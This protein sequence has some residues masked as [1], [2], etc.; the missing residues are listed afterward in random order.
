MKLKAAIYCRLSKED[1]DKEN[2]EQ[3][4]QSI[5]NQ[6]MMLLDY[7]KNHDFELYD[8]YKDDDYS[9][10]YDD[11]PEFERLIQDAKDGKFDVVIAKSQSR[12]TRNIEHLEKYLHHDFPLW[13]IR[14]ISVVDNVDTQLKGNKKARQINGLINEWYCEDLSESIKASYLIKQKMGQFLGSAPPYGYLKDPDDNHH[15]IPDPYASEVVKR[16]FHLY[17]SG[18]GKAKIGVILTDEGVMVPTQYK[19]QVLK[20]NYHNAH[21]K[22]GDVPRWCFQTIDGIL[23]DE[24]YIGNLVQNKCRKKSYKDKKKTAVPKEEWIRVENTHEPIIDKELFYRVQEQLKQRTASVDNF[25]HENLFSRLLF[26]GDCGRK[27]IST[28][29]KKNKKGESKRIY[30]CYEYKRFGNRFCSSHMIKEEDLSRIVLDDLKEQARILFSEQRK[31]KIRSYKCIGGS[32]TKA[33]NLKSLKEEL[34]KTENYKERVFENYADGLISK[35]EYVKLKE[36]YDQKVRQLQK[37]IQ[38]CT[39]ERK[40]SS[41]SHEF[42]EW[43]EKFTDDFNLEDLTRE[44]VLNLIDSIYIYADKVIEINYKFSLGEEPI[45]HKTG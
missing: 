5:V 16:I 17:E 37:D 35:T 28:V 38:N 36:K 10:L 33:F 20:L 8:I 39:G 15:L 31:E 23:R 11:R 21:I 19:R 22:E 12:F 3:E 9:G 25:K 13:G 26:C 42:E 6:T 14:F 41:W 2:P 24:V 32:Q 1:V 18:I 27:M 4:S 29:T 44:I 43:L 40:E 34:K 30:L 7:V 45:R